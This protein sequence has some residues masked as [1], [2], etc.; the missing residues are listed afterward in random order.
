MNTIKI[1]NIEATVH[2]WAGQYDLPECGE[3]SHNLAEFFYNDHVKYRIKVDPELGYD[4][5]STESVVDAVREALEEIIDDP[6]GTGA[7]CPPIMTSDIVEVWDRNSDEVDEVLQ[8]FG[9]LAGLGIESIDQA[10]SMGV[11][12]Y[13]DSL[14]RAAASELQDNIS[15]LEEALEA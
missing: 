1:E 12:Y 9:G 10:M 8:D 15:D 14:V 3:N 11:H 5:V 6:E 4:K 7:Y 2:E 13:L